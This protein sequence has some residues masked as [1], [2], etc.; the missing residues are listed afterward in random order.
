MPSNPCL[1]QKLFA[2][3]KRCNLAAGGDISSPHRRPMWQ[4]AVGYD[5]NL[6]NSWVILDSTQLP[7]FCPFKIHSKAQACFI[8]KPSPKAMQLDNSSQVPQ[9]FQLCVSHQPRTW[10]PSRCHSWPWL[11][12]YWL[13]FFM[14]LPCS[15]S[16]LKTPCKKMVFVASSAP[17]KQVAHSKLQEQSAAP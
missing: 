12:S 11:G 14:V 10:G 2:G 15:C 6:G 3:K 7:F 5:S 9:A 13:S 17:M 1:H 8:R 16:G 4:W